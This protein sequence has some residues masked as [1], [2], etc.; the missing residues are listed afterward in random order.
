MIV[1]RDSIEPTNF[2]GI[3]V[4][5]YTAGI[6]VSSSLAVMKVPP[7]GRH[8][9]AYSSRS[10]KYY[11]VALGD[12]QFTVEGLGHRLCAGDFVLVRRGQHFSYTNVT[13]ETTTLILVHTPSFDMKSEVFVGERRL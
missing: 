1:N 13:S 2:D 12:V 4:L 3:Q 9:E 6:N 5:D 11:Y 10:D 7:G 8:R